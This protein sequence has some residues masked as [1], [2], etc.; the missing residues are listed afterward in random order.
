MNICG[1]NSVGDQRVMVKGLPKW[2]PPVAGKFKMNTDTAIDSIGGRAGIDIIFRDSEGNVLA[3]CSQKIMVGYTPQV[4]EAVALL[5]GL[6]LA[7]DVGIWPWEVEL[8]A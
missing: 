6:M 7:Q 8:D 4:V 2:I 3:S 1:L 5:R